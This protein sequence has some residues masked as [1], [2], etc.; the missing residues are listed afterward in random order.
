MN[1]EHEIKAFF[2]SKRA[3]GFEGGDGV[4]VESVD[5]ILV[6]F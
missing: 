3:A 4:T 5:V 6:G 1:L 2:E